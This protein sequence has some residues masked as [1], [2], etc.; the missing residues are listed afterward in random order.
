MPPSSW[1][2]IDLEAKQY[3]SA[4][5]ALRIQQRKPHPHSPSDGGFPV[6]VSFFFFISF[7]SKM[8]LIVVLGPTADFIVLLKTI[9]SALLIRYEPIQ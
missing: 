6:V 7:S 4:L 8:D 3:Y 5:E 9:L 2:V 1:L